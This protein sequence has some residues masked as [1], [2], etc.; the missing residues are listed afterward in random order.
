[1]LQNHLDIVQPLGGWCAENNIVR[2]G[3][4]FFN[5]LIGEHFTAELIRVALQARFID[6]KCRKDFAAEFD[7]GAAMGFGNIAG[8]DH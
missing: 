8:A 6:V 1:M 2:L 3:D 5:L 4:I 7:N